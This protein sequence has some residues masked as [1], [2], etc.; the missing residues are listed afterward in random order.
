MSENKKNEQVDCECECNP[1]Q[2]KISTM[3]IITKIGKYS[4]KKVMNQKIHL[5]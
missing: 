3:T 1:S 4:K 5:K 2:L